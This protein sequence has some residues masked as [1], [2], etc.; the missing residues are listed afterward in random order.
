MPL[1]SGKSSK[2]MSKNIDKLRKEGYSQ[3]QAVAIA[4][5][6]AGKSSKK[7]KK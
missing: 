7:S 1:K 6:K 5:G 2:A 3:K 4:Y